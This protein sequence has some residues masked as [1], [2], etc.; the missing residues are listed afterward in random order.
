MKN[1]MYA[2]CVILAGVLWGTSCLFVNRLSELGFNSSH[3]TAIRILLAAVMLN[4]ALIIKGRGFSCYKLSL[5]SWALA[6][7]SGFFSVLAMC[8]FYYTCIL[9]TSA[10]VSAILLYT[11]PIFVMIMSVI[12]F[13]DKITVKK[14]IAL[15]FAIVG[16]A[17]VSGIL[18]GAAASF[19]GIVFGILSGFAY[20][21]YGILTN[22]FMKKNPE[23]LAF[24]ATSFIFAAIGA[25]VLCDLPTLFENLAS[26]SN[27]PL[28][29]VVFVLFSLCT[30]VLP[31]TLYTKGLV[32]VRP[33]VASILAFVEPLTAALIGITVLSQPFF[34]YQGVG[35]ACVVI[36]IVIL[37][38]NFKKSSR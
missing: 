7:A 18:S 15:V 14:V 27:I 29:L 1:K 23:P 28:I 35:I 34:A 12:F 11:A 22:F 17:L 38:V 33:D 25:A 24:S 10:A 2:A 32:G 5:S 16:C 30:A 8:L 13:K 19:K 3:C 4:A 36:A 20:S 26:Q 31:F 9:E 6:A 37:N 21:L